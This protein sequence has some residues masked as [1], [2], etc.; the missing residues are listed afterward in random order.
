[1][2]SLDKKWDA[3][4]SRLENQLDDEVSLKVILYLIGVQ[5]LNMGIKRFDRDEKQDVL[6]VAV[7]KVLAPFGYYTF[8]RIDEEGWPHWKE[9]KAVT[10]LSEKK[11]ELL[12]KKAIIKYFSIQ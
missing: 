11:Q 5:E 2:N 1:M 6:H 12:M 10:L 8:D 4:I 9:K 7:C 3:L